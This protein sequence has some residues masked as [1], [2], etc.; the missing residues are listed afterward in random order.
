MTGHVYF[1]GAGPGDPEL[2]TVKGR[3]LIR[4]ADLVLYADSLVHPAVVAE[5]RPG[6]RVVGTARLPLGEI[7]GLMVAAARAGGVVARVHSGDP[8][9][10]GAIH[11]QMAAL[12]AE[13]IPYTIVPGVSSAFAA[14]ARLGIEFTVPEV[15]QTVVFS[16]VAKRTAMPEGEAL[17]RTASGGGTIV[18]FL[19]A[20]SAARAV[21]E[22]LAAG[23]D[24]ETPAA[25]VQRAT[26]E[27]EQVVR[28]RLG[29]IPAE[30]RRRGITRHA[31][32]VVGRALDPALLQ[33]GLRSS[34]YRE[35]YS[36]LFRKGSHPV[37]GGGAV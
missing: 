18:L 33:G 1:I 7:L 19:S 10:Y 31:L 26:W 36:H 4:E 3:R 32:L 2:I 28:C 12:A 24:R 16:R 22:L 15:S 34:L 17:R 8:S 11:E 5:A 9:I 25:V 30:L 29:D 6:A 14:A 35:E 21:E 37:K 20:T 23:F 13:G 27:D